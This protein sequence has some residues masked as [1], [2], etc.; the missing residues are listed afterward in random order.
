MKIKSRKIK[1]AVVGSSGDLGFSNDV[2]KTA[3]NLGK[4]IAK[5]GNILACGAET[6]C[7]TLPMFAAIAAKKY[8][9][10]IL[11]FST[12]KNNT[13]FNKDFQV[14]TLICTGS[15]L[16]GGREFVFINSCDAVIAIGGGAGTLTE[17]LIAYQSN[18]P[19]FAITK[20]GGASDQMSGKYFDK[21]RL[22][23]VRSCNNPKDAV[24]QVLRYFK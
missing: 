1:I 22:Q 24:D 18:I 5:S 10:D 2:K 23:I 16:G 11:G 13:F 4:E 6:H 8:K 15:E 20:T 7:D 9:G 17:M 12:G 19:I 3:E 14:D 21:R